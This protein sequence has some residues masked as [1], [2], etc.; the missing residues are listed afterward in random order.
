MSDAA[1]T[2]ASS[3][4][5]RWPKRATLLVQY[6]LLQPFIIVLC[7]VALRI[8]PPEPSPRYLVTGAPDPH[9]ADGAAYFNELQDLISAGRGLFCGGTQRTA[10]VIIVRCKVRPSFG[11]AL[12]TPVANPN[13][14]S[15]P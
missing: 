7:L 10:L 6:L 14:I 1:P 9:Q 8:P 2:T 4:R 13:L 12:N 11:S 3:G 5:R 15:V